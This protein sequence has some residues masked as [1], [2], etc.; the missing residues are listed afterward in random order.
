MEEAMKPAAHK[1]AF[2]LMQYY[3]EKNGTLELLWNSRDGVTPFCIGSRDGLSTMHH[4]NWNLDECR[5]GHTPKAGDRIFVD[6]NLEHA[7]PFSR[8][9]VEK[10]WEH[11]EYPMKDHPLFVLMT[12]DE[13]IGYHAA[14]TV[15]D[16]KNPHV[17]TVTDE[18]LKEQEEHKKATA[19][20]LA[21]LNKEQGKQW[22]S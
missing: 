19:E 8:E 1:E 14:T 2:C 22:A 10:H 5:P 13:A 16:G 21:R 11:G 3:D 4:V 6:L 12:K 17:I 7:L 18:W 15:G 20:L 9:Y